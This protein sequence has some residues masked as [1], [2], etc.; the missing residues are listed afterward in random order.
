MNSRT[1]GHNDTASH[2]I[3]YFFLPRRVYKLANIMQV[4]EPELKDRMQLLI[5][6][7]L[8]QFDSMHF[9]KLTSI[10]TLMLTRSPSIGSFELPVSTL[11][12]LISLMN[13]E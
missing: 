1:N 5:Q 11:K 2:G 10:L 13:E 4:I 12:S 9:F 3:G 6:P 7:H 8:I